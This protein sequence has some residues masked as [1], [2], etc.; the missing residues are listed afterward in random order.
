MSKKRKQGGGGGGGGAEDAAGGVR[1]RRLL[2]GYGTDGG[3]YPHLGPET[4]IIQYKFASPDGDLDST[5]SNP[6]FH[7]KTAGN[8]IIR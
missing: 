8:E 7:I 6:I 1:R 2:E 3:L 5:T 4:S